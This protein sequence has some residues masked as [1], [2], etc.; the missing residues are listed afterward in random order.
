MTEIMLVGKCAKCEKTSI[1][2]DGE[3]A[4]CLGAGMVSRIGKQAVMKIVKSVA[5][6]LIDHL[7]EI[8][9]AYGNQDNSV[10]ITIP[11]KINEPTAASGVDIKIGFGFSTGKIT[12]FRETTVDEK[13]LKL[14][15]EEDSGTAKSD[16]DSGPGK[17]GKDNGPGNTGK[18]SG[19]G[20]SD[21]A[22]LQMIKRRPK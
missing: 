5:D 6:M 2:R 15:E 21:E 8:N 11:I 4:D 17:T 7:I 10:T 9:N 16:K 20:K 14:F 19:A 13:Q 3:C 22:A 1:L 18:D 12:D